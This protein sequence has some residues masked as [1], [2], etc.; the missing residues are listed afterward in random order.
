[1][2]LQTKAPSLIVLL[3][4]EGGNRPHFQAI[5]DAILLARAEV[6]LPPLPDDISN[7]RTSLNHKK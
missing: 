6:D 7:D 4:K 2:I 3:A 1:M 5:W